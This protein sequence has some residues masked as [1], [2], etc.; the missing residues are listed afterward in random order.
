MKK[1]NFKFVSRYLKTNLSFVSVFCISLA[2]TLGVFLSIFSASNLTLFKQL[3]YAQAPS[4]SIINSELLIDGTMNIHF[5]NYK[6][7]E[8]WKKSITSLSAVHLFRQEEMTSTSTKHIVNNVTHGFLELFDGKPALGRLLIESDSPD[9]IVISYGY[10][11][12]NYSQSTDILGKKILLNETEYTIVGVLDKNFI[13]IETLTK[14][15]ASFWVNMPIGTFGSGKHHHF[16]NTLSIIGVL[17]P[18]STIEDA[19]I[20]MSSITKNTQDLYVSGWPPKTEFR[21]KIRTLDEITKENGRGTATLLLIAISSILLLSVINLSNLI[22]TRGNKL[23]EPIAIRLSLG[24]SRFEVIKILVIE[25]SSLV[26]I[27]SILSLL[28]C[29]SFFNVIIL[30]GSESLPRLTELAIDSA[31]LGIMVLFDVLII[32]LFSYLLKK[33]SASAN[34]SETLMSG[35]KGTTNQV[36]N[37]FKNILVLS[38][39]SL[40]VL[41]MSGSYIVS[42]ESVNIAFHDFGI[43]K[44]PTYALSVELSDSQKTNG[45]RESLI[46]EISTLIQQKS[47]QSKVYVSNNALISDQQLFSRFTSKA[48]NE[49][50]GMSKL[51]YTDPKLLGYLNVELSEGRLFTDS[52]KSNEVVINEEIALS[53]A[54]NGPVL[55]QYII[56]DK[57]VS[58][59]VVG[60][61]KSINHIVNTF[62][63]ILTRQVYL[64]IHNYKDKDLTFNVT[65]LSDLSKS[66][67]D[68]LKLNYPDLLIS[69]SSTYEDISDKQT[70]SFRLIMWVVLTVF[71]FTVIMTFIGIFSLFWQTIVAGKQQFGIS[72]A[73]GNTVNKYASQTG[74]KHV[75]SITSGLLLGGASSFY[76]HSM[77]QSEGI[78][79][80]PIN[81]LG[82]S[83]IIFTTI[84]ILLAG[85]YSPVYLLK[86]FNSIQSLIK[87]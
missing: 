18:N 2:L 9:Q 5:S 85:I 45:N 64:S 22:I 80:L 75:L 87:D 65:N 69:D 71:M 20:E 82:I 50:I 74:M 6:L 42:E 21:S 77:L 30:L 78:I 79:S 59:K 39:I 40:T 3:P 11:N 76:V 31:T 83:T 33:S 15:P 14:E 52:I 10:W 29:K 81:I 16:E 56:T 44:T 67:T 68:A 32:V 25:V 41:V 19:I 62:D 63:D 51:T 49:L 66:I 27:S 61:V 8:Q 38:Q 57:D 28:V 23:I 17:N 13:T 1:I 24:A 55:G 37:R 86:K 34:I 53:L 54:K 43:N 36:T 84:I 26:I 4:I 35:N 7:A 48:S 70:F 12:Q 60:I 58:F 73:I 72:L 46:E 47:P